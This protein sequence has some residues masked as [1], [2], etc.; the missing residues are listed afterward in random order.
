[1][2][3]LIE[4]EGS[5]SVQKLDNFAMDWDAGSGYV[6]KYTRGQYVSNYMR[7]VAEPILKCHF[8][9]TI[10]MIF[11]RDTRIISPILW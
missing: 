4:E 7:A 10:R 6:D 11:S 9:E 2:K 3:K 1:M 5:F 8:E